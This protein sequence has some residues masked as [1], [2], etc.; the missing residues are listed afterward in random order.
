MGEKLKQPTCGA[1]AYHC[2]SC[3]AYAAQEWHQAHGMRKGQFCLIEH[4]KI[5]IC[6]HCKKPTIWHYSSMVYPNVMTVP[7]PN[8]DLN[9]DIKK[10]Y[11]EA[12]NIVN[13]SPRAAAALLRLCVQKLCK[14]LGRPGK[15]ID[16]DIAA[17]VKDG[18]PKKIQQALDVLR[19]V[20]NNAVHPGQIDLADDKDLATKLFDLLNLIAESQ[21][22]QP[23]KIGAMFDDLPQT[24]KDHIEKRDGK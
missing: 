21:L 20:G 14:Q 10:D 24:Q 11:K 9:T 23:K 15:K 2:P 18:L 1:S 4:F 19:V 8:P 13:R 16:D 3:G 6:S 17:L 12:A 7:P 22:T 5:S